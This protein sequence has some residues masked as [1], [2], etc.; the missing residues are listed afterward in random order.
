MMFKGSRIRQARELRRLT[1]GELARLI[2]KSQAAVAHAE[3]GFKEPSADLVSAVALQTRFPTSFFTTN[4]HVYFPVDVLLFRAR[5]TMTRRGAQAAARY[6]EIIFEMGLNL[7]SY[8][9][10]LPLKLEK[11][12]KSPI[13]AAREARQWLGLSPDE[14]IRHLIN[15]MERAGIL[16]LAIPQEEQSDIDA[17]SAWIQNTPVVALCAGK[18]AGDRKRFSAGHELGHLVLHFDRNI[19]SSEHKEADEFS[20][21]LLL[22]EK[23]MRRE[24]LAPVTL[25]SLAALKPR[26]GVSIQALVYRAHELGIIA[27]RQYRYLFEQI[28][29]RG[30]RTREP[31]NLDIP[32]EKP[33]T[34]RKIVELLPFG[35]N[36]S[37]LAAELHLSVENVQ[38]ILNVYDGMTEV[39]ST[40]Q[41]PV[42]NKVIPLKVRRA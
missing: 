33:R 40:E 23:A 42:S 30:W 28:S 29:I 16:V 11:S 14:P 36:I 38:E 7:S 9:T 41:Q 12:G 39:V 5:S 4:P 20:A 19:R 13:E 18:S 32:V 22:P 6:A 8:V 1:Q 21:E 17:F 15:T 31:E 3:R 24:I 37:H 2:G 10:T 34:L 26:W 25:T 27:D 35:N